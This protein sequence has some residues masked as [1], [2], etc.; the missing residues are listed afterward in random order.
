MAKTA[1]AL[2]MSLVSC[3]TDPPTASSN[4]PVSPAS[5][6]IAA[7]AVATS[8][9]IATDTSGG[10]APQPSATSR[11]SNKLTFDGI[12]VGDSLAS[13]L[14]RPNF[15]EPCGDDSINAGQRRLISFMA[16][17]CRDLAF[18]NKTTVILFVPRKDGPDKDAQPVEALVW[19]GG[20]YFEPRSQF[21]G[22]M[23]MAVAEFEAALGPGRALK[24]EIED[25][26]LGL[27]GRRT[28]EGVT[29]TARKHPGD[30]HSLTERGVA[31]GFVVGTM[32][33][34]PDDERWRMIAQLY[35]SFTRNL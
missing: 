3:G 30:V 25:G 28:N 19:L 29:L 11:A 18:P 20:T 9:P 8:A 15:R 24:P 5:Q 33:D 12:S 13:V 34:D 21:P 35:R 27:H 32:P 1:T 26:N 7:S 4:S 2:L 14:A 22:K 10:S 6:Q 31:I 23:G 16:K 17:P